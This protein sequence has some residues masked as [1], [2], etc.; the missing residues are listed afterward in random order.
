[1][2]AL[3]VSVVKLSNLQVRTVEQWIRRRGAAYR[4]P[5]ANRHLHGCVMAYRGQGM[6]FADAADPPSE[7]RLTLAHEA[8]HFFVDY[9]QPRERALARMGSDI[10]AVLDD[11]RPPTVS[12]R[13]HAALAGV[14]LVFYY[15]LMERGDQG[16][17]P[18]SA[19]WDAEDR[20]DRLALELL[21]PW[22]AVLARADLTPP[23][24][25]QRLEALTALL[26]H[27]FDLPADLIP[28]YARQILRALGKGPSFLE[29]LG[30]RAP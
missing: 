27:T 21:A 26:T 9:L 5:C 10:A 23:T 22:D 1:M 29:Q 8:A 3:P 2:Q 11:D 12:E 4:F 30:L 15:N 20:A 6:I 7:L 18:V 14:P 16:Q 19:I 25:P 13:V 17:L 28:L 24:Y